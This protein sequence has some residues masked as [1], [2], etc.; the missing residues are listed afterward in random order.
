M[1][2]EYLSERQQSVLLHYAYGMMRA[3]KRIEA[4]ERLL[5]ETLRGQALRGVEAEDVPIAD[6]DQIFEDRLTRIALLLELVGVGYVDDSFSRSESALITEI[7]DALQIP[8]VDLDKVE[9]WVRRQFTL[10]GE[11]VELMEG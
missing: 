8:K 3:D 10:V 6:L 5:I 2:V 7:A 1:F 4:N 9:S 11:A